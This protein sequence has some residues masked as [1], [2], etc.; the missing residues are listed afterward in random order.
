MT[1][2]IH[3]FMHNLIFPVLFIVR[4]EKLTKE[5]PG[6]AF[7]ELKASAMGLKLV[8][9]WTLNHKQKPSSRT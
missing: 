1:P 3:F 7:V 4:V 6:G 5:E 8:G 9:F 2:K